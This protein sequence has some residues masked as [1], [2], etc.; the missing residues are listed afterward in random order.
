VEIDL[1][2]NRS[3][4]NTQRTVCANGNLRCEFNVVVI[5]VVY[6]LIDSIHDCY[7]VLFLFLFYFK[8]MPVNLFLLV[9]FVDKLAQSFL[10][11]ATDGFEFLNCTMYQFHLIVASLNVRLR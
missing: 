5:C 7:T 1:L 4:L 10:C 11:R 6:G 8:F 9:F 3:A 2:T